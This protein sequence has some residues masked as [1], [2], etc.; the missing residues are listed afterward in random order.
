MRVAVFGAGSLGSVLGAILAKR[1][2]VLL[3]TRGEHYRAIKENGLRVEGFTEGL[4]N[5]P[6]AE[7]YP[8]GYDIII[9]A[10]KAYQTE[11]AIREIKMEY[12]D[13]ILIT[14]QNGVGIV[15]ML[16]DFDVIPGVTTH[17]AMLISPGI[18][19]H[20]GYGDT[21][22]G[23]KSGELT[24]RVFEIAKNFTESGLKT[25]VVN[26]I[27]ERRWVKAAVNAVINPL[28]AIFS[29]KNGEIWNDDNLRSIAKCMSE[30]LSLFLQKKG[31]NEDVYSLVQDVVLKTRDNESSM[32]QDIKR[33]RKTE[34]DYIIKPF[35]NSK[36]MYILYKMIKYLE[37]G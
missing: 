15:D 6:V 33:G 3:I 2:D 7:H 10:V 22:I 16:K 18:V 11:E 30:E 9:L 23:E 25:E 37:K 29:I 27:M 5:I 20:A 8:G 36:C 19:K 21:F 34:A 13:E 32:L 35:S 4:F 26:D 31:I 12:K 17:G 1:N 14:F 24:E 28:T